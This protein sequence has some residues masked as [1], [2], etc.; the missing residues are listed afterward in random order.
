[1]NDISKEFLGELKSLLKK[2]DAEIGL[3]ETSRGWDSCQYEMQVWA[4]AKWDDSGNM[5][6]DN[7]DIGLGTY[8]D[9][10]D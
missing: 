10:R 9:G 8:I 1:M 2:Y 3:E 7:I 4:Y 6:R 5:I